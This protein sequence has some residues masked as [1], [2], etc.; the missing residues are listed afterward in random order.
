MN[1][2]IALVYLSVAVILIVFGVKQIKNRKNLRKINQ[3]QEDEVKE[4]IK[5]G[6]LS[7]DTVYRERTETGRVFYEV[8]EDLKK[9]VVLNLI[10]FA[11]MLILIFL[12]IKI[13]ILL[14][15]VCA[16]ISMI[17]GYKYYYLKEK[18]K[19]TLKIINEDFYL[20]GKLLD[21]KGYNWG[22]ELF[23]LFGSRIIRLKSHI[24]LLDG[25]KEICFV[26]ERQLKRSQVDIII[27]DDRISKIIDD[28]IDVIQKRQI[29]KVKFKLFKMKKMQSI[30][31]FLL[32]ISIV[33]LVS[34]YKSKAYI[35][36][37]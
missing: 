1:S 12:G 14:L 30:L 20:N 9:A 31:L 7:A 5:I 10:C 24:Y 16:V 17:Y 23:P 19:N 34:L 29:P 32:F 6:I 15:I 27:E 28:I 37:F 18:T 22:T 2:I 8:P 13:G 4:K 11:I 33:I 21:I 35:H 36:L 25:K 26:P 3:K